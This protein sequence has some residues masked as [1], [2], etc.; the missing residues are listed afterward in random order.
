MVGHSSG[1]VTTASRYAGME[2]RRVKAISDEQIADLKAA[3]GMG[4]ALAAELN[5]YPGPMHVLEHAAI[6]ES[7]LGKRQALI[8][9]ADFFY[10]DVCESIA[11]FPTK[12][13]C[14]P[15]VLM[16]NFGWQR[17]WFL[18]HRDAIK[19]AHD[20]V[21]R[22]PKH[23]SFTPQREIAVKRFKR[24]ALTFA[25][26]GATLVGACLFWFLRS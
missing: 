3:R 7:N 5:E 4:L 26:T 19:P 15:V 8:E 24:I 14:R 23:S 12:S 6:F 1:E 22:F 9:K 21:C 18:T 11:Q 2:K 20:I 16:L 13:L 10:N 25:I 17:N